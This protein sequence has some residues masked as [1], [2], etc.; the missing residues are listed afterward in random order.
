MKDLNFFKRFTWKYLIIDEAHRIKNEKSLLYKNLFD[1]KNLPPRLL[2]TG[3]PIQNDLKELY[4]LLHFLNPNLFNDPKIF[5]QLSGIDWKKVDKLDF[6]FTNNKDKEDR[7]IQEERCI[8]EEELE[9]KE[10]EEI[11][12]LH[13]ILKPFILRRLKEN[14]FKELPT[15]TQVIIYTGLTAMQKQYYRW[16]LAKDSK[17]LNS[18]TKT[19]TSLQN[20]LMQLRKCSNHPYLF[21]GAEP[22]IEGEY[23][24]GDHIIE[25][26]G[27]MIILNKS[28]E[29][30]ILSHRTTLFC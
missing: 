15:L 14:V 7:L 25:N 28:F 5:S 29:D 6:D 1:L 20:I 23:K 22:Q 4:S 11:S 18:A 27:K 2:L 9:A 13:L 19:K 16:I 10:T 21:N 12:T 24:I 26:S 17:K 30:H 8:N 3:T